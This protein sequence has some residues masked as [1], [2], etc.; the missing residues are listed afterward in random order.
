MFLKIWKINPMKQLHIGLILTSSDKTDKNLQTH[1]ETLFDNTAIVKLAQQA[2]RAKLDFVF[3]AD[4]FC[5]NA[6][7]IEKFNRIGSL[8]PTVH[9]TAIA[10][11]TEKIG[12]VVTAS[13]S[14]YPPYIL[15][16]QL[17]SLNWISHGRVGWNIV[18][19]AEGHEN[20]G[21]D[22]IMDSTARYQQAQEFTDVMQKL[23]H[24]YPR[25]ALV[26][27]IANKDYID[28]AKLSNPNHNGDYLSVG[29]ILNMP[30]HPHAD[31]AL[32]QA[33]ESEQ[34]RN[35]AS[36]N[37]HAIFCV[38][39]TVEHAKKY[40]DDV[41]SRATSYGRDTKTI[42]VMPGIS[43][44]LGETMGEANRVYANSTNSLARVFDAE[45][46]FSDM[47]KLTGI[48][49]RNKPLD[50]V[51][52]G[53]MIQSTVHQHHFKNQTQSLCDY[54]KENAPT[55]EALLQRPEITKGHWTIIGTPHDA[56]EEIKQWFEADAI[57]GMIMMQ[58]G[59]QKSLDLTFDV[60]IPK[61][62]KAGLFRTEYKE[63]GL[64]ER[65]ST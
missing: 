19:S 29:G 11:Q 27:D 38:A 5:M 48:D 28:T 37:A 33:G 36:H 21:V 52:T 16:R 7:R 18:T 12:L 42:K 31:I 1:P 50:T 46:H 9:L 8:C 59:S 13:T 23:W 30:Q 63:Q 61:L 55:I 65:L 64:L 53:D 44:Y 54:I 15:A 56:F 14:F 45:N 22:K 35:F 3:R 62:Q 51:I 43:L 2:E 10:T 49:I 25:E 20:F 24:S 34:G 60:L 58:T 40:R 47:L 4:T 32:F 6:E 17:Q 41:L 57:D 26:L 39:P